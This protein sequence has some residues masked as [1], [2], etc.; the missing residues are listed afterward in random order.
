M[1]NFIPSYLSNNI[2]TIVNNQLTKEKKHKT[3]QNSPY[4]SL[5][6]KFKTTMFNIKKQLSNISLGEKII[7]SSRSNNKFFEK[8]FSKNMLNIENDNIN[9]LKIC[10]NESFKIINDMTNYIN[11][12]IELQKENMKLKENIKFLLNQNKKI[13]NQNLNLN[14]GSKEDN[15]ENKILKEIILEY[16]RKLKII[17][18]KYTK[19]IQENMKIKKNYNEIYLKF[20]AISRNKKKENN[21]ASLSSQINNSIFSLSEDTTKENVSKNNNDLIEM[22]TSTLHRNSSSIYIK[23]V[24]KLKYNSNLKISDLLNEEKKVFNPLSSYMNNSI[25]KID[26]KIIRLSNKNNNIPILSFSPP[27]LYN[28]TKNFDENEENKNNNHIIIN[29]NISSKKFAKKAYYEGKS[30][31]NKI[32]NGISNHQND[33]I[34]SLS[35]GA[36]I[37][38]GKDTNQM[39]F[40]NNINS[41]IYNLQNLN[42]SHS[43]GGLIQY[44]NNKLICISGMQSTSV[45]IYNIK[46]N[47]WND[48]PNMNRPHCD[49]S[50]IIIN[51]NILYAFF[52]FDSQNKKYIDDIEYFNLNNYF[53]KW[54]I[55]LLEQKINIRGHSLFSI[56]NNNNSGNIKIIL[57]GGY[58]DSSCN[59]GLIEIEINNTKA[60]ILD[61]YIK[62]FESKNKDKNLEEYEY[63]FSTPFYSYYEHNTNINYMYNIDTQFNAHVIDIENLNHNVYKFSNFKSKLFNNY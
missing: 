53:S 52:G 26:S 8:D 21:K 35:N 62:E 15:I 51:N 61:G 46:D 63:N 47:Q 40:Y 36:I 17:E 16:E 22:N 30:N 45:E 60:K 43:K 33:L 31:F 58:N 5:S 49:S 19:L 18:E 6:N 55:I 11:N 1:S 9:S 24:P 3:H 34:L 38:T 7:Y 54:N 37:I 42:H 48:L 44:D 20:S 4:R 23:K 14:E 50:Y 2:K 28:I 12:N 56:Y 10:Q 39:F 25:K 32:Y 29:F 27:I 59:K 41:Y 57:I 13:Q